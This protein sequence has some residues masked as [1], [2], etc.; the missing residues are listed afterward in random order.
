MIRRLTMTTP[1]PLPMLVTPLLLF[2]LANPGHAAET[3]PAELEPVPLGTRTLPE[4]VREVI[5]D[6]QDRT[7]LAV[8][9]YLRGPAV[10]RETR[11]IG[12]P[13]EPAR[14]VLTDVPEHI[15]AGTVSL[16][17][18]HLPRVGAVAFTPGDLD[19]DGLLRHHLGSEIRYRAGA[20]RTWERGYLLA[21]DADEVIVATDEAVYPLPRGSETRFAFPERPPRLHGRPTLELAIDS[22]RGGTHPAN[23]AYRSEGLTWHPDYQLRV[24]EDA[25][26]RLDGYAR[27]ENETGIDLQQARLSLIG[28]SLGDAPVRTLARAE[29]VTADRLDGLPRFQTAE[30]HDLLAGRSHRIQLFSQTPDAF[31]RYH[32][33][34]SNA[35]AEPDRPQHSPAR[36]VASWQ[37]GTDLPPGRVTLLTGPPGAA[38]PVGEGR[39]PGTAAGDEIEVELGPAFTVTGERTLRE[40]RALE[41]TEGFEAAWRIRLRNRG[42]AA[43]RIELEER[44]PGDWELLETSHEPK[45]AEGRWALWDLALEADDETTL[46]YRVRVEREE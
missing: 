38:E 10:F 25:E 26:P 46:E 43:T 2:A 15:D 29:S 17:S 44:F 4:G 40:R 39:I 42:E 9:V 23:L 27:V 31:D 35:G 34:R 1:V 11:E 22:E 37:A 32:R 19:E 45:R 14:L 36:R 7:A 18:E 33:L 3:A 24:I 16:D 41:T 6:G 28:A 5:S 21:F 30:P 20:D 13:D 8:T 12:L